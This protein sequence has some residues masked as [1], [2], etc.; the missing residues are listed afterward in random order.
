MER[1]NIA[2]RKD[3]TLTQDE[4]MEI[5]KENGFRCAHCGKKVYPKMYGG[6]GTIDH[7]VPLS[8]GGI[9]QKI[10]YVYLCED[11]NEEKDSK[12]LNP[13]Q[14]LNYISPKRMNE[15]YAYFQDYLDGFE[16]A[17]RN[18]ILACDEYGFS[19]PLP[20]FWN[21]SAIQRMKK[22]NCKTAFKKYTLAHVT[23]DDMETVSAFY[24]EYLKKNDLLAD[25]NVANENLDFWEEFGAIYGVYDSQK[26]LRALVPIVISKADNKRPIFEMFVFCPYTDKM[27]KGMAAVIS[28]HVAIIIAKER[29]IPEIRIVVLV[30]SK[31]PAG[32]YITRNGGC[33]ACKKN[34]M[35]RVAYQ[36]YRFD[37]PEG[38]RMMRG[39][40]KTVKTNIKEEL[41]RF[42]ETHD[43][44]HLDWMAWTIDKNYNHEQKKEEIILP[45]RRKE[46]GTIARY[47][48]G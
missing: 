21:D 41:D 33:A 26:S 40:E 43:F 9:N 14:Y 4:K 38:Y 6:K 31:D 22:K 11:C 17:G 16:Y 39:F 10:N 24:K 42:F 8:K 20:M 36:G 37:I 27:T 23:E 2:E 1:Q 15:L 25:E 48:V 35:F 47:A 7:Y 19:V 34:D 18:N 13:K 44:N 12:I 46:D 32:A 3:C 30:P 45:F 5:A 29:R 28:E